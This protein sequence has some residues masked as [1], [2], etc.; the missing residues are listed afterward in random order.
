MPSKFKL[1]REAERGQAPRVPIEVG[2]SPPIVALQKHSESVDRD[3]DSEAK[4][5][6]SHQA[7]D[8]NS[9][10]LHTKTVLSSISEQEQELAK[11]FT[12]LGGG[13]LKGSATSSSPQPSERD[14]CVA[15]KVQ[16]YESF[17]EDTLRAKLRQIAVSCNCECTKG[18]PCT[19]C[20][21]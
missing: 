18:P 6:A 12:K 17:V 5:H 8:V 3:V 11:G 19:A 1:D 20:G 15:D 14:E 9:G 13:A 4:V 16:R 7:V 10:A 21:N 2:V